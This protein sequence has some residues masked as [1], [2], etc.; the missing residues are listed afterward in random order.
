MD[1]NT[2]KTAA[3]PGYTFAGF[4][5][6]VAEFSGEALDVEALGDLNISSKTFADR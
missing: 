4:G 6:A 2:N 3:D 5:S 1:D